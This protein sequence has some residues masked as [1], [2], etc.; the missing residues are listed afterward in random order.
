MGELARNIKP[1]ERADVDPPDQTDVSDAVL[2]P[3]GASDIVA[4]GETG[5]QDAVEAL[6]L[7][8]VALDRVGD[9]FSGGAEEVV[10]LALPVDWVS[11]CRCCGVK[12]GEERTLAPNRHAARRSTARRRNSRP[13]RRGS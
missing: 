5:V 8:D 7:A 3:A 10:G 4:V 2:P 12:T 1:A 13:S 6:R 11:S 9:L